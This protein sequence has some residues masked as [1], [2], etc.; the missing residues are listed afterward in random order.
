MRE[1]KARYRVRVE[2]ALD[3]CGFCAF[4]TVVEASS[5]TELLDAVRAFMD[6][7]GFQSSECGLICTRAPDSAILV[8]LHWRIE[9]CARVEDYGNR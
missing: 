7:R 9:D 2:N 1:I 8:G 5:I 4:E 3:Y 6:A